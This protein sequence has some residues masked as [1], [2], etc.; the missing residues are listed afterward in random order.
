MKLKKI[1]KLSIKEIIWITIFLLFIVLIVKFYP[2]IINFNQNEKLIG[3]LVSKFGKNGPV[4]LTL[5]HIIQN[6]IIVFPGPIFTITGVFMYGPKIGFITNMIGTTIG[7]TIL[8]FIAR[9]LGHKKVK[10]FLNRI[11]S[12]KD[13]KHFEKMIEKD[14][15]YALII[16]RIAPLIPT[17]IVTLLCGLTEMEP[18]EFILLNTLF[19]FPRIFL[20]NYFFGEMQNGF[21]GPIGKILLIIGVGFVLIYL[22]RHK[23][24][25]LF[26]KELRH[27]EA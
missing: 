18:D 4:I 17:E 8:F 27:I 13:I 2:A 11:S 15:K 24:K 25:K 23:L 7:S 22:F 9:N 26:I 6:I 21:H 1:G 19:F 14:E 5:L 12:N 3:D 20:E 10:K 16:S